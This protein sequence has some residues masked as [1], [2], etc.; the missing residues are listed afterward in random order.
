MKSHSKLTNSISSYARIAIAAT[1][2]VLGAAMFSVAAS[3]GGGST[4]NTPDGSTDNFQKHPVL[5]KSSAIVQLKGEPLSKES[6]TKPAQG[7][8]IDFNSTTVK[9]YRAQLAA[10]RNEFKQWLHTY[11]PKAKV[12][13]EYGCCLSSSRGGANRVGSKRSGSWKISGRRWLAPRHR[14]TWVPSGIVYPLNSN[15]FTTPLGTLITGG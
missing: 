6:S 1:L 13:S 7:K 14:R 8:K 2:L 5:D 15:S 3:G 12:T 10:R 11:A 9:S 4:K